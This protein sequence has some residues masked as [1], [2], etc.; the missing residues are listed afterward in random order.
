MCLGAAT[1]V[2]Q[3]AI[4]AP[5]LV[6]VVGAAW[7]DWTH[8]AGWQAKIRRRLINLASLGMGLFLVL[9]AAAKS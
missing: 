3:V 1:L 8:D 5:L 7:R 4:S 9:A 2:K 6:F